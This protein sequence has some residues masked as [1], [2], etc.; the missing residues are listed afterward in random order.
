MLRVTDMT[1]EIGH[2]LLADE[3]SFTVAPGDVVGLVGP[4]GAGKTSLLGALAEAAAAGGRLLGGPPA[5]GTR[6]NPAVQL[7][8]GL[9]WLPQESPPTTA[10]TGLARLL[11]ARGLDRARQE[12]EAARSRIDQ[13]AEGRTRDR[14]IKRFSHLQERFELDGG[15]RAEAEARRIAAG[16]GVPATGLDR[17]LAALSGGERR[18]VELARVLLSEAG[19]L[20]LDEPTNHLDADAKRW[21]A[22][23]LAAFSGG[24]LLV[25]HDLPLLDRDVTTVLVLDPMTASIESYK[26]TWTQ[27]LRAREL[28]AKTEARQRK[29]LQRDIKRLSAFVEKYRHSN[30]VMARRA[31]VTERRVER[32]KASLTPERRAG[33]R[34]AVRFP[35]PPPCA[36]FPLEAA[37]LARAYGGPPVFKHLSFDLERG[38]RLLVLGLNGAGK[39]SLLRLLAGVDHPD[40]GEVRRGHGCAIGYY[41]QEHEGLDPDATCMESL[42]EVAKAPDDVLRGVLGHFLL[43]GDQAHQ[44]T[45]TLSGGEKTKLAL[46]RLVLGRHN[47]L[48]LDEPTNNLDPQAVEAVRAALD[49]FKGAVVLV[50]HDTPFVQR[51]EPERVL[52]MPEGDLDVWSEDYLDLVALD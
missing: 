38:E 32:M 25:S 1:V 47:V 50:S 26:G 18:R 43:G 17:P 40:E 10:S 30:E 33:R 21:L 51:F 31:L 12:L 44:P 4:N 41:A 52:L 3:V 39:T 8:G 16:L 2:R 35:D 23:F 9:S 34:V 29:V 5:D 22:D 36:R 19:T 28:R 6:P 13:A 11:S 37:D 7:V 27:Y 45:R 20:L 15:Y 14:A 49:T 48:L 42:R 46:A 24:I